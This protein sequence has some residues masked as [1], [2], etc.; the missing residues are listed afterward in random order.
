MKK[1]T[2]LLLIFISFSIQSQLKSK[3]NTING[4]EA[5]ILAE[6]EREYEIVNGGS[7][8][9]QWGSFVTGG[10][11]NES[12]SAK[13]TKYTKRLV[14]DF[15]KK[16]IKFDAI[17]Y[18]NGKQ[19]NAI[20]FVDEKTKENDR[21][22]TVHKIE[23]IPF[24]VLSEPLKEYKYIKTIGGGIKWKSAFTAGL[25]NNSIEQDLLKF[26]K[27]MRNKF[28]KNKISAIMYSR[29]KRAEAIK[30]K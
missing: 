6:P 5:Y 27:K 21:I 15:K 19:M 13:I 14:K 3:V 26:A 18:T 16:G 29:G 10:L 28:R 1:I 20:K 25:W 7:K 12:I 2:F 17:I 8:G 24:Y 23:G 30:F 9:I 22:A 11:I 4:I